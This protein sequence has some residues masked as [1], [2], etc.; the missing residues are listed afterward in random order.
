MKE[1]LDLNFVGDFVFK[2]SYR[3]IEGLKSIKVKAVRA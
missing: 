2:T 1:C 3:S